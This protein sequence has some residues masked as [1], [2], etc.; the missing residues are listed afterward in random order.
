MPR[1]RTDDRQT[2]FL[3]KAGLAGAAGYQKYRARIF[4]L[5]ARAS[6]EA[7]ATFL[8][9]G[10][11]RRKLARLMMLLFRRD[12]HDDAPFDAIARARGRVADTLAA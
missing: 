9:P 12:A 3:A 8:A 6:R 11:R 10:R 2:A 1:R 7:A 4:I 5:A